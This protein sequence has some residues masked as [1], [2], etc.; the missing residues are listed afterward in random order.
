M[1][2]TWHLTRARTKL[3]LPKT[4]QASTTRVMRMLASLRPMT[5]RIKMQQQQ[6]QQHLGSIRILHIMPQTVM[7]G[8]NTKQRG[9][10]ET[11]RPKGLR[12]PT[13]DSGASCTLD[14]ATPPRQQLP[15]SP[16]FVSALLGAEGAGWGGS[17]DVPQGQTPSFHHGTRAHNAIPSELQGFPWQDPLATDD[18][19]TARILDS[20]WN[21]LA[22]VPAQVEER[23]P[24]TWCDVR[25]EE[26]APPARVAWSDVRIDE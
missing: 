11:L 17:H 2:V 23:D 20:S 24:L 1:R 16:S 15:D 6:Q 12:P 9:V 7:E 13:I 10:L 8:L 18:Q 14:P 4:L 25:M 26:H 3:S 22:A 21:P 19:S 5:S